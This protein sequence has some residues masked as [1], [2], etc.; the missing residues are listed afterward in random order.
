M[1]L[2]GDDV[3]VAG[4]MHYSNI[5]QYHFAGHLSPFRLLTYMYAFCMKPSS[6]FTSFSCLHAL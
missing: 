5:N 1:P 3:S 2:D 4:N 6:F